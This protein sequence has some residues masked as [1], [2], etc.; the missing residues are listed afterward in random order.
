MPNRLLEFLI[1][2]KRKICE[3]RMQMRQRYFRD[4]QR[5]W[6]K[7]FERV[8]ATKKKKKKKKPEET[9]LGVNTKLM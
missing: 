6:T 2:R 9:E 5:K 1:D 4:K 7:N 3:D 8:E